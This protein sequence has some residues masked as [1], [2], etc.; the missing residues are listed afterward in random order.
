MAK[1]STV[2][3]NWLRLGGELLVALGAV[4][5]FTILILVLSGAPPY[6]AFVQIIKG[7]L[8]SWSKFAHVVKA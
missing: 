2:H 6:A 8:G 7:S 1:E 4:S 3:I 5:A